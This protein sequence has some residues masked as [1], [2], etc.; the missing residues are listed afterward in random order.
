MTK[1]NCYLIY[2]NGRFLT[3]PITG[4]QRYSH[5]LIKTI[6]ELIE[7]NIIDRNEFQFVV[8]T[9]P[10][11]LLHNIEL[12]HIQVK[13]VGYLKGHL[14]EQLELPFASREG[15]LFCPGNTARPMPQSRWPRIAQRRRQR[16]PR[17]RR[18]V[19]A[20]FPEHS[21]SCPRPRSGSGADC[22]RYRTHPWG[23]GSR[24]PPPPT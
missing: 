6:D 20:T 15:L 11:D 18:D 5:E 1:S 21:P 10:G 3:Q 22:S 9:P 2:I 24:T 4:V 23:S 7:K 14:W 19:F 13:N 12:I 17:S 8:L 16:N